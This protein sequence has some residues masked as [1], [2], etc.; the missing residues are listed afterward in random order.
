MAPTLAG[1]SFQVT[2]QNGNTVTRTDGQT[3]DVVGN[4]PFTITA[5][6]TGTRGT[7]LI[8]FIT[9]NLTPNNAATVGT[10]TPDTA[11]AN[12]L[13]GSTR[14]YTFTPDDLNDGD[15]LSFTAENNANP[16]PPV[17]GATSCTPV[18]TATVALNVLSKFNWWTEDWVI[19]YTLE[20]NVLR[21]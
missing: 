16:N 19:N 3:L 7:P 15:T 17:A 14:T 18:P 20:I 13:I 12:G 8:T 6:V 9:D 4:S 11:D 21:F 10:N 1:M 5:V 2:D